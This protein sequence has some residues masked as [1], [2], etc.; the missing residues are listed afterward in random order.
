M[1][2]LVNVSQAVGIPPAPALNGIGFFVQDYAAVFINEE[3]D[4][5]RIGNL[6][7]EAFVDHSTPIIIVTIETM[8]PFGYHPDD[9]EKL[10]TA[11]FNRWKIG[12]ETVNGKNQ[13]IMILLVKKE[14]R[15]RIELGA[16]WG[17]AFD[18]HCQ[19]IMNRKMVP[20]FKRGDYATGLRKGTE[21]LLAMV[22]TGP[23]NSPSSATMAFNPAI[24]FFGLIGCA[25]LVMLMIVAW[26]ERENA[27]GIALSLATFVLIIGCV[28]VP[29]VCLPILG[30]V[31]LGSFVYK[32][33]RIAK[34]LDPR[35]QRPSLR[36]RWQ[37][38]KTN[39]T[40]WAYWREAILNFFRNLG[41]SDGYAIGDSYS[42]GWGGGGG[43]SWGGGGGF[44]GGGFSGGSS[45]G[46]GA[47]G[48]W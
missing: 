13:G 28:V 16:D 46:G 31:L 6:Q 27:A 30:L 40:S 19:K 48:S 17:L 1:V 21:Q 44:S 7:E 32:S 25:I 24:I 38:F 43:G 36:D 39:I 14:R 33:Y 41:K 18:T 12:T 42:G 9:F 26:R 45:G 37:Q 11:W 47:S 10:A 15:C 3:Q 22:Q 29:Y 34:G 2:A 23:H 8:K 5:E 4:F 35:P 20:Y